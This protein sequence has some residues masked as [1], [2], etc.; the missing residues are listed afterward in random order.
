M[1]MPD[2]IENGGKNHCVKFVQILTRK[3]SVSGHFSRNECRRKIL[4]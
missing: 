3:N 1:I 2:Y 4:T